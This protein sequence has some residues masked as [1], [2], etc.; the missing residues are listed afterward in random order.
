MERKT[1]ILF[2]R[3]AVAGAVLLGGCALP[4]VSIATPQPIKVNINMKLD[5][6]QHGQPLVEKKPA[7]PDVETPEDIQDRRRMRL[8]ELQPLKNSRLIGEN[9]LGL[10]EVRNPVAGEYG[11]YVRETIAAENKDRQALM[12]NMAKVQKISLADVQKQQAATAVH[13]AFN[14]EWIETQKPG[15]T[16]AWTQKGQE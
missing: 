15:G 3:A 5:V 10:L 7:A 6:Y 13:S 16:Y 4:P 11:D 8:G 1:T 14:G 9:H 2:I 12:E